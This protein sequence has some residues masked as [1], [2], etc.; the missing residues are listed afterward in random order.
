MQQRTPPGMGGIPT[1]GTGEQ[2]TQ[3]DIEKMI[4]GRRANL[5]IQFILAGLQGPLANCSAT[6]LYEYA[7][8]L[9]SHLDHYIDSDPQTNLKQ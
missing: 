6:A 3:A 4:R 8:E 2:P 9:V 7:M 1:L 5:A